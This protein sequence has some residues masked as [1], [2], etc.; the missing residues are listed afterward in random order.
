VNSSDREI[1]V[2]GWVNIIGLDWSINGRGF[3]CG[4]VSLQGRALLYVNLNGTA[5]VLRQ[6]K[7]VGAGPIWGV[8][9]PDGRS[10]VR[11]GGTVNS[12]V[13]MLGGF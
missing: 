1:T 13:W 11:R 6:Y 9:S 8:P 12:N 5:Q 4:S 7:G 3:Y 10:I 2:E